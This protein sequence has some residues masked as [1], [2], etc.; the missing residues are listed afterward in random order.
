[1]FLCYNITCKEGNMKFLIVVKIK[2]GRFVQWQTFEK[3]TYDDVL[4][5]ISE[6]PSNWTVEK[7]YEI[8]G[9]VN[10]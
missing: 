1:M 4:T 8:S 6:Y 3:E 5:S 7:V 2:E 10:L 9:I